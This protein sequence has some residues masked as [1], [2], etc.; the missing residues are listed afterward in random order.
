MTI[1]DVVSQGETAFNEGVPLEAAP[2]HAT[3]NFDRAWCDGWWNG[4]AK[5]RDARRRAARRVANDATFPGVVA[6]LAALGIDARE[7][8]LYLAR[9]PDEAE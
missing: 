2:R 9:V 7:L 5:A 6:S 1:F 3:L 8:K 4:Y